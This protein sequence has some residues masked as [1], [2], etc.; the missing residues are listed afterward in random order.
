MEITRVPDEELKRLADEYGP[1]CAAATI[2]RHLSRK[3]AKDHQVFAWQAGSYYFVGPVPD[4]ET[5]AAMMNL[6]EDNE[7][8]DKV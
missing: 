1:T 5:E 7:D 2:L 4:A 8:E 6:V 3:R